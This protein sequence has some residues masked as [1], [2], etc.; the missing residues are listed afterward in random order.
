MGI[1][2]QS[3]LIYLIYYLLPEIVEDGLPWCQ[4]KM[5]EIESSDIK[6]QPKSALIHE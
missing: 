5:N 6:K 4:F 3:M 2:G 1:S